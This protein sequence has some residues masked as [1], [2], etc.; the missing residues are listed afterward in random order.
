MYSPSLAGVQMPVPRSYCPK[1]PS[2][3]KPGSP[4]KL[5]QQMI[6]L[7]GMEARQLPLLGE[8]ETQRQRSSMNKVLSPMLVTGSIFP[9]IRSA[10]LQTTSLER[11]AS[12]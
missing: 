8:T 12:L 2:P 1:R 3:A 6:E 7:G 9:L 5:C 4:G 11:E 10:N